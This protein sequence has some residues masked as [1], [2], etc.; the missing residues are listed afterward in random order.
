V[1]RKTTGPT[2]KKQLGGKG[3]NELLTLIG[4]LYQLHDHNRSFIEARFRPSGSLA[5]Y[6]Q[7][8][9]RAL[10][11]DLL[12]GEEVE[13]GKGCRTISNYQKACGDTTGVLE[14]MVYYVECGNGFTLAYGDINE[15][16]YD[17]LLE[18]FARVIKQLIDA[19]EQTVIDYLPRLYK[20]VEET[21]NIGWGYHDEL[22]DMLFKHFPMRKKPA[23]KG[24]GLCGGGLGR[25]VRFVFAL[26]QVDKLKSFIGQ[27]CY[28]R[29][30]V[31]EVVIGI[32]P[33][34]FVVAVAFLKL[35]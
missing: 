20:I 27:Q 9:D 35:H 12:D 14:L 30:F 17:S 31:G 21:K 19:D 8:I 13:L 5:A 6:K 28:F 33:I 22:G 11:P 32:F 16:F 29:E 10:S 24:S 3:K 15:E 25:R 1:K 18:M 23:S 4:D 26:F 34:S 7:R 2:L